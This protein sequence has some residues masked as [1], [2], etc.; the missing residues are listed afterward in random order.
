MRLRSLIAVH[1]PA[2]SLPAY[3][4][5]DSCVREAHCSLT[6]RPSHRD[7]RLGVAD[8]KRDVGAGV[9]QVGPQSHGP[10]AK[11]T[12]AGDYLFQYFF[13]K[14]SQCLP[15]ATIDTAKAP[16]SGHSDD[17]RVPEYLHLTGSDRNTAAPAGIYLE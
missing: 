12:G 16:L 11:V 7:L 17:G 15:G 5:P 13:L 3:A 14:A 1:A 8:T 10:I 2:S 9:R 6:A 4:T